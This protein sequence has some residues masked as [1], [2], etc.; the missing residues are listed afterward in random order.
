MKAL[1]RTMAKNTAKR[2][3][4]ILAIQEF[5]P[6]YEDFYCLFRSR[7]CCSRNWIY[8]RIRLRFLKFI[9]ASKV[10]KW[11]H[12]LLVGTSVWRLDSCEYW[13]RQVMNALMEDYYT[14]IRGWSCIAKSRLLSISLHRS[15]VSEIFQQL[16]SHVSIWSSFSTKY[17]F[18]WCFWQSIK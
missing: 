13:R 8:N 5:I 18:S 17:A 7:T 3:P 4:C 12:H 14:V 10:I 2:R 1:Y 15:N 11:R 6:I 9:V 16:V